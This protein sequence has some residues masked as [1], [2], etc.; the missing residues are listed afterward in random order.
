MVNK[1]LFFLLL[2]PSVTFGLISAEIFPW[3]FFFILFF[4]KKIDRYLLYFIFLMTLYMFLSL[5]LINNIN[6][7]NVFKSYITYLNPLLI[8]FFFL[9]NYKIKYDKVIIYFFYF[10][11]LLGIA[12]YF[13]F[14]S[15][16]NN[17]FKLLIPRGSLIS[18][19]GIG[20]RGVTLLSSEP[21]RASYELLFIY[22][23]IRRAFNKKI[24]YDFGILLYLI[25][26]V[27]SIQGVFLAL[28]FFTLFNLKIL[29]PIF[30]SFGFFV[31][32]GIFFG[33]NRI[34][35]L[36]INLYK[37]PSDFF[38]I[39]INVS[40]TRLA[41]LYSNFLYS[42]K[43]PFGAGFGNWEN[44]SLE[45]F[46]NSGLNPNKILYFQEFYEGAWASIRP[47][48]FFSNVLLDF[49]LVGVIFIISILFI[50]KNK[51]NLDTRLFLFFIFFLLFSADT[52]NPIPWLV[53]STLL[54][55]QK[56][57]KLKND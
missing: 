29:I 44:S 5:L 18:L 35:D 39:I 47:T 54:Y 28:V 56:F 9:R 51:Y 15:G 6:S 46:K 13:N 53:M 31:L 33:S 42:F 22:I 23:F 34:L 41:S 52:G 8:F 43:H 27:K 55:K 25:L 26:I 38:N 19:D 11:I 10:L 4:I 37:S 40:G 50:V 36:F 24:I 20:G 2:I 48:S 1:V 57:T 49:G 7:S 21:S 12:Q 3:S 32:N 16:I 17:F 45:A 30:L 14:F